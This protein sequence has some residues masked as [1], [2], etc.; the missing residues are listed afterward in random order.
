MVP[1]VGLLYLFV[2]V[3]NCP[4]L[5]GKH[6]SFLAVME[7]HLSH[8]P[9]LHTYVPSFYRVLLCLSDLCLSQYYIVFLKKHDY[10]F[11]YFQRQGKGGRK[12]GRETSIGRSHNPGMC[13]DGESNWRPFGSQTGT[14]STEPQQPGQKRTL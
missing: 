6:C 3:T 2:W 13:P 7:C 5:M 8:V 9:K 4:N 10:L 1:F 12:R 11:I 14:Q